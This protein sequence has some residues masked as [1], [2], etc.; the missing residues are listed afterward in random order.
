MQKSWNNA[1]LP[2]SLNPKAHSQLFSFFWAPL[3]Q[4]LRQSQQSSV[5]DIESMQR[6]RECEQ[7][8]I[9]DL[10]STAVQQS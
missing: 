9:I 8:L 6:E 4:A 1:L 2:N 3:A 7:C 5:R 10:S